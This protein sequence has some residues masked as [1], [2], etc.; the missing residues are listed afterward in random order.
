M[1]CCVDSEVRREQV[2]IKDEI[3]HQMELQSGESLI[4]ASDWLIVYLESCNWPLIGVE[5]SF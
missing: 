5:L 3:Q 4:T 2:D 1:C